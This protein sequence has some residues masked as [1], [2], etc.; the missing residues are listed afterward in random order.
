MSLSSDSPTQIRTLLNTGQVG[1]VTISSRHQL[2][3][4][5]TTW[6][7]HHS[8]DVRHR[9]NQVHIRDQ[10]WEIPYTETDRRE[11]FFLVWL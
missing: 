3:S 4:D 5:V 1:H 6:A 7:V 11:F 8:D 2:T 9:N 10:G